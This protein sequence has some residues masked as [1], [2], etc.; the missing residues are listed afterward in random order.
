MHTRRLSVLIVLFLLPS[1][2]CSI[3][4]VVVDVEKDGSGRMEFS[5][6]KLGEAENMPDVEGASPERSSSYTLERSSYTFQDLSSVALDGLRF[7]RTVEDGTATIKVT[8][9]VHPEAKWVQQ[10]KVSEERI[11]D[12]KKRLKSISDRLAE[13]ETPLDVDPE[14]ALKLKMEINVPEEIEDY[15]VDAPDLDDHD[16]VS[17]RNT[18]NRA[19]G[20]NQLVID[21]PVR[22]IFQEEPKTMS[23]RLR[24]PASQEDDDGD[25]DGDGSEDEVQT[26]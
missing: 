15:E 24:Y 23:L 8:V 3:G 12:L 10:L 18:K 13:R 21:I 17:Q 16:W 7:N 6:L 20:E 4:S 22:A 2:G 14:D 26:Y 11:N 5:T 25:G 1:I 19:A 9:P